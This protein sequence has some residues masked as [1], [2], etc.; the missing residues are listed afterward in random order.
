MVTKSGVPH[1]RHHRQVMMFDDHWP[2]TNGGSLVV[3]NNKWFWT[4]EDK[5]MVNGVHGNMSIV[6]F[7]HLP[8]PYPQIHS[9]LDG[10]ILMER[11]GQRVPSWFLLSTNSF[12]DEHDEMRYLI[13]NGHSGGMVV[14]SQ[15][16]SMEKMKDRKVEKMNRCK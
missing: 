4:I 12:D 16:S 7:Y 15:L 5:V 14:L 3:S 6:V 9:I 1:N 8:R 11:R 10:L 13:R 2:A